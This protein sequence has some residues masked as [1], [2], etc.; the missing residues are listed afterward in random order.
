MTPINYVN[1]VYH[2][3]NAVTCLGFLVGIG[4]GIFLITRK[5]RLAGALAIA[6]FV[7]FS[8]EPLADL[9]I[10]R[11]LFRNLDYDRALFD[12]LNIVYP[13][14]SGFGV[15]LGTVALII[16]L[17]NFVREKREESGFDELEMR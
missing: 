10:F 7:L 11:I 6:G 12:A 14:I 8:L 9:V 1:L 13:C 4:A 5:Q 15:L 17:V 16:A 3:K 2:L